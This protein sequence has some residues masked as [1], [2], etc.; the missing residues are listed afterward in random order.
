[1]NQEFNTMKNHRF[2]KSDEAGPANLQIM[3]R[4]AQRP[5]ARVWIEHEEDGD[6]LVVGWN[7]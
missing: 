1:M 3:A 5:G 6:F 4:E 7:E 2:E